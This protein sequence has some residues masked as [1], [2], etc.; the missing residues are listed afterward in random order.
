[1][2]FATPLSHDE[3]HVE[4]LRYR[5]MADIL[6]DQPVLGRDG[7]G[8][9]LHL[10]RDDGESRAFAE[11]EGHEA[12]G[13]RKASPLKFAEEGSIK[14]TTSTLRKSQVPRVKSLW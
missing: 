10:T 12:D 1:M 2:S 13:C 8:A 14:A 5:T 3:D 6:G 9:V 11:A 4:P 7:T